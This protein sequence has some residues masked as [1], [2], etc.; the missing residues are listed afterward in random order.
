MKQSLH[1]PLFL[2]LALMASLSSCSSDI[3]EG[4]SR[5]GDSIK[6]RLALFTSAGTMGNDDWNYDNGTGSNTAGE[7][8]MQNGFAVMVNDQSVV[9]HILVCEHTGENLEEDLLGLHDGGALDGA[10]L[11]PTT[12]GLKRFFSFANLTQT[13]VEQAIGKSSG[14]DFH[15]VVGQTVDTALVARAAISM[16]GED[17][18]PTTERG[19]PMTGNH[20]MSLSQK[21]NGQERELYVVRLLAKL[22]FLLTNNTGERFTVN[23]ITMDRL[24]QNPSADEQNLRMF[25]SPYTPSGLPLTLMP[26]LTEKAVQH[27]KT[28][29][30][31]ITLDNGGK[32]DFSYYVNETDR[33][34]NKFAQFLITLSLTK[35]DGT[36]KEQRYALVSNDND[37]W[38]FIARNDWRRIPLVIQDLKLELIPRDFP[39]IGVL[40]CSVKGDEGTFTCTFHADGDFHLTPRVTRYSNGIPLENWTYSDATWETLQESPRLYETEP[41]WYEKGGYVHGRFNLNAYGQSQHVLTITVKPENNV[42]RRFTCPVIVVKE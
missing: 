25:P 41:F 23:S 20:S 11:I 32:A 19:I 29:P 12:I 1:F 30:L 5:D 27:V 16:S 15:F 4:G 39:A 7:E 17:F 10:T 38:N 18:Q 33:P 9:E 36:T 24:T 3:A 6:V 2:F 28:Y 37:A 40:P 35:A 14:S 34:A 31:G 8:Y 42:A 13:E 22:Q 26:N 21:D